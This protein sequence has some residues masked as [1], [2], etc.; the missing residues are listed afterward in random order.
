[1]IFVPDHMKFRGIFAISVIVVVLGVVILLPNSFKNTPPTLIDNPNMTDK[2]LI[3]SNLSNSDEI[4]LDDNTKLERS[5]LEYYLDDNGTKHFILNATDD[6][7]L[8][9]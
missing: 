3:N 1:M 8:S 4:K 9:D 2:A 5:N 7:N 6:V